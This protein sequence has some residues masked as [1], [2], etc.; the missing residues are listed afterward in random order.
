MIQPGFVHSVVPSVV[1]DKDNLHLCDF[2]GTFNYIIQLPPP[3]GKLNVVIWG[4][5]LIKVNCM[6]S[7]IHHTQQLAYYWSFSHNFPLLV[8]S[9]LKMQLRVRV[10]NNLKNILLGVNEFPKDSF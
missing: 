4:P 7:G 6:S 3:W 1:L 8:S 2:P 10:V 5:A 9:L